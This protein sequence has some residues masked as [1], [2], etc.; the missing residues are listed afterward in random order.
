MLGAGLM[1]MLVAN[2]YLKYATDV[3]LV[4]PA[5][6]GSIFLA[7]RI[8][9]AANDPLVGYLSDN[10]GQ[11]LT[12]YGRRKS[13]IALSA[14]PIGLSFVAL[15]LAPDFADEGLSQIIYITVCMFIF[16]TAMTA[17]YVPHYSMAAELSGSKTDRTRIFGV[18]A[19]FENIG[20]FLA[21]PIISYL[22]VPALALDRASFMMPLVAILLL[23]MIAMLFVEVRERKIPVQQQ[24]QK[25]SFFTSL[26]LVG[27]NRDAK[28]VLTVSF[29]TQLGATSLLSVSLYYADYVLA[30]KQYATLI[31]GL[32][33]VAATVS[34][35]F[36]VYLGN[37]HT[38]A[39]LAKATL[40]FMS[41][42]FLATLFIS[43]DNKQDL[44]WGVW[45]SRGSRRQRSFV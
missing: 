22:A 43:P 36:W 26:K 4:G 16:L 25:S 40:L 44:L 13:F 1:N 29:F 15:W 35:P 32:F 33:M 41:V 37:K 39:G 31:V 10:A 30:D 18:R 12:R 5:I 21:V 23:V 38:K 20:S 17:L 2:A 42:G 24:S 45:P 8:W 9:D 3:L 28:K 7:S 27:Q 14:I 6:L 11:R 34:I 19:I